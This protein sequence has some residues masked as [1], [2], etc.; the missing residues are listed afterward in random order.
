MVL[1]PVKAQNTEKAVETADQLLD[2]MQRL[3][4]PIGVVRGGSLEGGAHARMLT[5]VAQAL[6][7]VT[8]LLVAYRE[9]PTTAGRP[10]VGD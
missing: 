3:T 9:M 10:A 7:A 1:M 5:E 6:D 4:T 8:R 2:A